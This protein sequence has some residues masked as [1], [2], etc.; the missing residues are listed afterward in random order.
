MKC[1]DVDKVLDVAI[2]YNIPGLLSEMKEYGV[3]QGTMFSQEELLRM[4]DLSMHIAIVIHLL[5]SC[6]R[7]PKTRSK[8][9]RKGI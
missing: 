3:Q 6:E 8:D 4:I 7:K 9:S 5:Y 2:T 1:S